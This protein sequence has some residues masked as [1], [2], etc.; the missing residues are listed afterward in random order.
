MS[1][2]FFKLNNKVFFALMIGMGSTS[3]LAVDVFDI[4]SE[5]FANFIL[6]PGMKHDAIPQGVP[7][8]Y[9]WAVGPR[10]GM[11]NN[12]NGYQA[13]TG[14]GQVFT[15]K[16]SPNKISRLE[17]RK[18]RFLT[19]SLPGRVWKLLQSE[20]ISGKQFRSDYLNNKSTDPL[21]IKVNGESTTVSFQSGTAFHF[22]PSIGQIKLPNMNVCG[23]LVAVEARALPTIAVTDIKQSFNPSSILIGLGADYWRFQ[24]SE[25]DNYKSNSDVVIGQLKL[26]DSEWAWYGVTTSNFDDFTHLISQFSTP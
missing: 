16:D 8:S 17:L 21:E 18:F 26:L 6:L 11:A 7:S 12:P 5:K 14:W 9:D 13:V 3:C 19:C 25:W 4:P 22:W 20:P 23:V 1:I 10:F 2:N 15:V 24:G